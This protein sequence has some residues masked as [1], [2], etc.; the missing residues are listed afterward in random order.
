M[1]QQVFTPRPIVKIGEVGITQQGIDQLGRRVIYLQANG[2]ERETWARIFNTSDLRRKET[3]RLKMIDHHLEKAMSVENLKREESELVQLKERNRIREVELAAELATVTSKVA[4]ERASMSSALSH[5]EN[6]IKDATN[7][8]LQLRGLI[9]E[10]HKEH[11]AAVKLDIHRYT[12][13]DINPLAQRIG[14]IETLLKVEVPIGFNPTGA[15]FNPTRDDRRSPLLG[16]FTT[17]GFAVS[18]GK[19]DYEG[20]PITPK[21]TVDE[22]FQKLPEIQSILAKR[23]DGMKAELERL[24]KIRDEQLAKAELI[25]DYYLPGHVEG[26]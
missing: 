24:T 23:L 2:D 15:G 3:N 13:E 4:K 22:F 14:I 20:L 5:K 18:A 26:F 10:V 16:V 6:L 25:A 19:I 1:V 12:H 17:W 21:V 11:E 7:A 9:P 8:R